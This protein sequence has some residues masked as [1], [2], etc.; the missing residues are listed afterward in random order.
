MKFNIEQLHVFDAR[1]PE[2]FR[3]F[4]ELYKNEINT[5]KT[6]IFKIIYKAETVLDEEEFDFEYS[7]YKD[8]VIKFKNDNKKSTALSIQLEKCREVLKEHNIECYNLSIEGDC[9]EGN[10]VTFILE[11]DT[12]NPSYLGR[13]KKKGRIT[14]VNIM[15]NKKSTTEKIS[16]FFNERMSELFNNIYECIGRDNEIMC[17]ILDVEYRDDLNYAYQKFCKE[18]RDWWFADKKK[19]DELKDKIINRIKLVLGLDE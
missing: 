18:Y 15:P 13:G 6:Y 10:D 11:E 5:E 8:V 4:L 12:S 17:K 3:G 1:L 14:I 7:I 16:E 9:I 19:S 2:K